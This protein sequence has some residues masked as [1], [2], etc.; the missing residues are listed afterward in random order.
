MNN[1]QPSEVHI[2]GCL[3]LEYFNQYHMYVYALDP[4]LDSILN[5]RPLSHLFYDIVPEK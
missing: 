4:V 1:I 5:S 3:D 2:C